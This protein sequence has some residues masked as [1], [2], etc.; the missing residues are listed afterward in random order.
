VD[1][2]ADANTLLSAVIGGRAKLVLAHPRVQTVFS[3]EHTMAEVEEYSMILARKKRLP[4]DLLLLAVAALPV[5][6][7]TRN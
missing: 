5:T 4:A 3:T 1:L 2:V 6:V 7:V